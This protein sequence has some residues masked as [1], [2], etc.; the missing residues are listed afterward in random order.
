MWVL[1]FL[2]YYHA[3]P[4]T[5]FYQEWG[6]VALGLGAMLLLAGRRCWLT[7][8]VPRIVLLPLGMLLIV[9]L[10][11]F[12]G[13]IAF[14]GQALLYALYLLWAML[15]I[16]LGR[17]L[18]N[19]FGLPAV[20]T[21]LA[22][23]LLLGGEL[24][25]LVGLLQNYRWHTFLDSVVTVKLNSAVYGN[26]AQPNH[27]ADYLVLGLAS[28]GLLFARG[29]MRGWQVTLLALPMLYVLP[30]SGSRSTWLYLIAMIGLSFVWRRSDHALRPLL[31]Y[32][33]LV[34]LGF[35][36]M[37]LVVH[38][39]W[40]AGSTGEVT[41]VQRLFDQASGGIR[42][43]L[44]YE[45]ML[46]CSHF[47]LLGAGFGQFA[48]QH[49]LLG[50]QLR[51]TGMTGLYNHAHNIVMQLAA[52]T[53]LAGL[54]V[55]FATLLPWLWR[56]RRTE[57]TPERWWGYA[58]LAVLGIHSLLE[59]PLWYAYFLGIAALLLGMLE[60]RCFQLELR[61]VGRAT[62][63][64]MLV[65]GASSL[66]QLLQGYRSIETL[67]A[68]RPTS[69]ADSG[70][71]EHMRDGLHKVREQVLLQPYADLFIDST[72]DDGPRHITE[73]LAYNTAVLHFVPIS[74]V[75]YRQALLLAQAGKVQAAEAQMERAIWSYP[76]EFS[77]TLGR[78]EGMA[79]SDPGRF[80]ALLE[81]AIRKN[82]EYRSAV[83]RK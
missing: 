42:L 23:F 75:A 11:L 1:P 44:W 13:R 14:P 71:V 76:Q 51:D 56:A 83:H 8:E 12:L 17:Q 10:Q 63:V 30:L 49:F 79:R 54:L 52:E 62:V 32:S 18:R 78:L 69:A 61:N 57:R 43:H 64:L 16:M 4:L 39:P 67:I 2:N 73:K 35:V 81:F 58:L 34:L 7:P 48:W 80:A 20:A 24:S 5:T 66:L 31:R 68:L 15:L 40:L 59:Y 65:L 70:Y 46:I 26:I 60:T 36:L 6:A 21:V 19:E 22:S 28:L 37:H 55:L 25:A 50:P 29:A 74:S 77:S 82:E 9:V 45:A 72:L 41:G 33:L 3:Y 27:F 53:G 47:P 38:L